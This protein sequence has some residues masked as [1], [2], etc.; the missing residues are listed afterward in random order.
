VTSRGGPPALVQAKLTTPHAVDAV[1]SPALLRRF[2]RCVQRRL[3][4]VS[5]PAGYGKTTVTVA[6][7]RALRVPHVWYRAD[8]LDNDPA[9]T[10][11]SLCE[12]L[13]KRRAG[14]AQLLRERL[15][16]PSE[17]PLSAEGMAAAFVVAA[18]EDGPAELH[19]VID[20]YH[21]ATG[22]DEFNRMVAYL[23]DNLPEG[24][25]LIVLGRYE[26]G[27]ATARLKVAGRLESITADDL[28]F[29]VAQVQEL[30]QR[31]AAAA[32]P[33]HARRL[34]ELTGGWP[35]A[36][37]LAAE[38][39]ADRDV[40]AVDQVVSDP[41]LTSD[42]YAY[43]AEQ[44][45]QRERP[46]VR[47]FLKRTCD[48]DALTPEIADRVA[49]TRQAHRHLEYLAKNRVF[50]FKAPETGAYRYH[51]L[52]R[53]YLRETCF[54]EDGPEACRQRQLRTAAVLEECREIERSVELLIAAGE[55]ELALDV[56]ARQGEAAFGLHRAE[57][58]DAWFARLP[59]TLVESHPWAQ[60]LS[61]HRKTRDGRYEQALRQID[62]ATQ[63]FGR[64]DDR[65]GLYAA[66]S[67]RERA[68]FWK[69]DPRAALSA[70]RDALAIAQ[71]DEQRLH[72][73]ASMLSAA[74]DLGDWSAAEAAQRESDALAA[75]GPP[76]ELLRIRALHSSALYT[77]GRFREADRESQGIEDGCLSPFFLPVVLGARATNAYGLAHYSEAENLGR[78]AIG[79]AELMG[80]N[81]ALH[82]CR[83]TLGFVRVLRDGD[84]AALSE[85]EDARTGLLELGDI[86]AAA[87]PTLHIGTYHR[88]C[89][90]AAT[91][92]AAYEEAV[93]MTDGERDKLVAY[94][95]RVNL[96]FVLGR[97][98]ET[99]SARYLGELESRAAEMSL[100]FVHHKAAFFRGCLEL[101]Q[102]QGTSGLSTLARAV[103]AQVELGH[104]S[105]L[106]R[107]L[108]TQ[109]SVAE[110]LLSHLR[111]GG[112][113][114]AAVDA[115]ARHSDSRP[116]LV[117]VAALGETQALT[118]LRAV[119]R[120]YERDEVALVARSVL[121]MRFRTARERAAQLLTPTMDSPEDRVRL[122]YDLTRRETQVLGLVARGLSNHEIRAALHLSPGTVKTHI[123]H[124]FR[125]LEV[126]DRVAAVLRYNDAARRD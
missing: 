35:A 85:L 17:A 39:L 50:T 44:V 64:S 119:D 66:L 106:G 89:G 28:R 65:H 123:N 47:R 109:S 5:A 27:F 63:A 75:S 15:L 51:P 11:L 41:R 53:D 103:A 117:K 98:G 78:R 126:T 18:E 34:T 13:R 9:V 93:Q 99:G 121:G 71:S 80:H 104:L 79:A 70:C 116:V 26:P 105:F 29:D 22:S 94:N 73:Y 125:K 1:L 10:V 77:Q 124:I 20:D 76:E 40:G 83:D 61:A 19:L 23:I 81:M 82:F 110:R 58:L 118:V 7:L 62:A 57:T 2:E 24:W 33:A 86:A 55:P 49:D 45:Y 115:M 100:A 21:E 101:Q 88:R 42:I 72:T 6:A 56:I 91:A 96:A 4:L 97:E 46:E 37:S 122:A 36:V 114:A 16:H 95:A 12:A 52:F 25:R 14:F 67:A 74:V 102:G 69:G 68:L 90:A 112:V 87:W 84:P 48:L 59:G 107:E 60:L 31:H 111:D 113:L 43:M 3:T 92:V 120:W 108:V 38:T 32:G 54:L 30:L 8:V